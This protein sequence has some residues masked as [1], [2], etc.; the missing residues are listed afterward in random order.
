MKILEFQIYLVVSKIAKYFKVITSKNS[1]FNHIK[2]EQFY[3]LFRL[4]SVEIF[5]PQGGINHEY[6]LFN[7][8]AIDFS[9]NIRNFHFNCSNS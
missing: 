3:H 6:Y 7:S 9:I 4:I 1:S 8:S 2:L 5:N